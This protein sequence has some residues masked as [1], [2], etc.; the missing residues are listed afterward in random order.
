MLK[1]VTEPSPVRRR[2]GRGARERILKAATQLFTAQGINATGMDQLSTV[3]EVSKR[4][5]Y[6]HFPSKDELV[7]AYLQSLVDD[8]LPN[9]RRPPNRHR[10]RVS[11]S[12]PS[13]TGSRRKPPLRSG[14]ARS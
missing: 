7:G 9:P 8:L 13:S 6:T 10:A 3:A 12:S 11:N 2:R 14:D 1:D 4:T 5:L